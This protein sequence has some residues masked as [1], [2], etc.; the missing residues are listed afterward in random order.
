MTA[1]SPDIGAIVVITTVPDDELAVK[2]GES[3]LHLQ[4]AACVHAFPAGWSRYRWCGEI[5]CAAEI[6]L[7]IKTTRGRYPEI[8]TEIRRLHTYDVPEILALSV[9]AGFPA[10]L[11]WIVRE[12]A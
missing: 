6:T 10:Y 4:L 12:T 3:L 11:D 2:I 5:E 7:M 1:D 8:E 9:S